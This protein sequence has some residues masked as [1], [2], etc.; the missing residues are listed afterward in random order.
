MTQ[1]PVQDWMVR[2]TQ[3]YLLGP[4]DEATL[5]KGLL[6]GWIAIDDEV[7]SPW[8]TSWVRIRVRLHHLFAVKALVNT[9]R[10][11]AQRLSET[12]SAV[13]CLLGL[14]GFI[15]W[16]T[17][18][19][20]GFGLSATLGFLLTMLLCLIVLGL[21]EYYASAGVAG[22]LTIPV[23]AIA[24]GL[25][26]EL[27]GTESETPYIKVAI[28]VI[29]GAWALGYC[30]GYS[31]GWLYGLARRRAYSPPAIRPPIPPKIA[32]RVASK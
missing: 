24:G 32:V 12:G 14:V 7:D 17:V 10:A 4:L 3:G 1:L 31:F 2:T 28:G 21:V 19:V 6:E 11:Y 22:I 25:F 30:L 26:Q 27:T 23:I 20:P 29:F 5:T 13:G 16:L 15:I 9:P 18:W 8:R